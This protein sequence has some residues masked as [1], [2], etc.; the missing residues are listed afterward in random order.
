MTT[1]NWT[2]IFTT[3][4]LW[5]CSC[6]SQEKSEIKGKWKVAKVENL[7]NGEVAP[8]IESYFDFKQDRT[9][10]S[11]NEVTGEHKGTWGKEDKKLVLIQNSDTTE[12]T[13]EKLTSNELIWTINN[14]HLRFYLKAENRE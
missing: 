1:R 3:I 4:L 2:L 12:M 9:F 7:E 13:I 5:A 8:E 10:Q 6:V 11:S 14:E